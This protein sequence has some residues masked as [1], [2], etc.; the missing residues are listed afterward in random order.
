MK[1]HYTYYGPGEGD[2]VV[3]SLSYVVVCITA[4]F[5]HNKVWHIHPKM[6]IFYFLDF[7]LLLSLGLCASSQ[8]HTIN[9][10][11]L[12]KVNA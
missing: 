12:S 8:V 7:D 10:E 9:N 3:P 6:H 5:L 2:D 11:F 4:Y 1:Y